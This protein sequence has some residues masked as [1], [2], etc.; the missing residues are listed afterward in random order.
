MDNK[1]I[2]IVATGMVTSVG[3]NSVQTA[4]NVRAKTSRYGAISFLH[5]S[6]KPFTVAGIARDALGELPESIA[7]RRFFTR[8]QS[9]LLRLAGVALRDC[10]AAAN[11]RAGKPPLFFAMPE[12]DNLRPIEG[13]S[14]VDDLATLH[15]GAFDRASS[16]AIGKGRAGGL[17][18]LGEAFRTIQ[19]GKASFA[20]AGGADTYVDPT[21][22][23]T[24]A[25]EKRPKVEMYP[26]SFVPG[27]GA[28]FVLIAER[29]AARKA[30]F[31]VLARIAPVAEGHEPGF[32]G[33][34][35]PYLGE[36]L[37]ST[38]QTLLA[39]APLDS[40]IQ[41]V[42]STMNGESYWVK[43]WGVTRIR[44]AQAM[45]EGER[46]NHPSEC[47]GDVGAAS[48]PILVALAA[49]GQKLAYARSPALVY[50]SSDFGPRA[51][52]WVAPAS[53]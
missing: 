34:K 21:I 44:N 38:V 29:E 32:W 11:G 39:S 49:I 12:H 7:H 6:G 35:E 4:A 52:T 51:A 14:V 28:G 22:L 31:E 19:S 53:A 46:M 17:L 45:A 13:S 2:V 25:L 30:G 48:G 24:L 26:D 18:A 37:A 27:E 40:P 9:L 43:E 15:P 5:D 36:G 10:L 50:A 41:E 20:F 47:F 3:F 1:E 8:R 23:P 33:S 16:Q 42:Y